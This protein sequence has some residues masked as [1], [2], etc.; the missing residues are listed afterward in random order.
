MYA[1]YIDTFP[2][3]ITCFSVGVTTHGVR[4]VTFVVAFD[5]SRL[6]QT[7]LARAVEYA[8][9]TEESVLAVAVV[10][11]RD[12]R[13]ARER[14]WLTSEE[15][16]DVTV[17]SDRLREL[18][19]DLSDDVSFRCETVGSRSSGAIA[20]RLRRVAREADAS[21]VFVGSDSAGHL[22]VPI[23][24]VGSTVASDSAYDVHI[25][26]SHAPSAVEG[27]EPVSEFYESD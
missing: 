22:V 19:T 5:G 24:S 7:A 4:P 1:D 25:V 2:T 17:V 13:Y 3:F 27:L 20:T 16:F 14:G 18:V 26:R 6:A 15:R 11:R 8:S 23:S 21:V 9:L 10:P 12:E